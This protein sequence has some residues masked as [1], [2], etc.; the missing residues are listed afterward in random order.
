MGILV[1]KQSCFFNAT[2]DLSLGRFCT[3][4]ACR[5]QVGSAGSIASFPPCSAQPAARKKL[6]KTTNNH[7]QKAAAH[8]VPPAVLPSHGARSASSRFGFIMHK[9]FSFLSFFPA[10][11]P[12]CPAS[13]WCRLH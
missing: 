11:S 2:W 13:L 6:E 7:N 5:R 4:W 1:C 10:A 8:G 3:D 12:L 9:E